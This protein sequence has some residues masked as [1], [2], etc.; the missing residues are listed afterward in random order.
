MRYKVWGRKMNATEELR[1]GLETA[2]IDGTVA[3]NM[4]F[5][6]QFVSN[7]YKEGKKVLSSIE[8]ELLACEQFQISVAFITMGGIEPLLQ[9]LKELEKKH[10]PGQILTTNYLNF[11]E[12]KALEKL[13][14]LQNITLKMYDVESAEEG[15]H[16]KGYIFKK[17]EIYRII[18]GS[19]NMTKSALTTNKEWN[20]KIISTEQGEVAGEIIKEFDDLWHSSYVLEFDTFY[21]NYKEKYNIIKRQR[22]IAKQEQVTFLEKYKLQP[23]SMQVGFISNLRKILESGEKRALLISATGTG[24]TYASAF[25]MR[26]LGFKRV[27]FLV[28]RGQL[29]RQTK[30][31][32]E[33]VFAN[34][35][36]M[37][38][39]GA[40]YHDYNK[41]YIFATVQTLNKDEHLMEYKPD[42]FD[43]I[44][45]DEAHHTSA[46]IYQKVMNYFTPK[47]WLGM[48]ATPDKRDDNIAGRNIYEIFHYQ[49]AYEIRLQQAMEE[50]LLCPFHYFGISD[51]AMLG[52]KQVNT[53]KIT[54]RD[55]NML[56]G[57][58]R[59]KHIV[60]QAHYFGYSG[61]KV[62][63]LVFCSRIEEAV[64]LSEKFNQTINPETGK[65]FRTM[66]LSGKTSEEERQRAFERLA[67]N[68]EEADKSNIP[69]DYIFSVEI[70]NEGVDIVEV[71]Q[72]IMLRP[73]ES[74][75]VFIQQLGRGLR[76]AVGKEFVVV[77]DFIGNYS[78]NFMIPIALS[79]DRSY[80]ADTIRKYVIS[81][82]NTIPGAS[83]VHFDEIAKD[84]IFA[85]IDKIKGMK[86]IIRDSYVSLKN[87]LGRVPYLLDF[88]E[89][90]EVDPLVIIKEYKTYQ[91]FLKSMEK[92]N[93]QGKFTDDEI[94]TLEY[95]SKTVLS[96]ARP[97]E[98]EILRKLLKE[99]T[100]NFEK[101]DNDFAVTYGYHVNLDSFDNAVEVLQGKFVSKEE[102]YQKYSHMDILCREE[103]R[104]LKRLIGFAKRLENAEFLR[105][106]DDIV[107]V[108]LKRYADKYEAG[109]TE[110]SPFVIYEKYSRRDVSLLMN[111]GKDLSS[112]MYGMKRIG[113][114]TFIFVTYHKEESTDDK[115]Y[116]DGKP[117]YADAFEDN[118]I[119]LWDSQMGRGT[120]SSYVEDVVQAKRKHLFVK[121]SDA[122]TGFYY[123]G[124]FDVMDVK[125]AKKKDNTGKMRDIAKLRMKM[126]HAVREDLLRYLQSNIPTMEEKAQ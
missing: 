75:I 23:N 67:M 14:A 36:S 113:D 114:D 21:E 57:E 97:Y 100:V 60:E 27:L 3:S 98:L 88:Y 11:S 52:D 92:E 91:A 89:N 37:G 79:G 76:K 48:T 12:P 17:E 90:G 15:F 64:A 70:L 45:L 85:S 117:D 38:L 105:Q 111:C 112:T 42:A 101:F 115:N 19:S 47:L 51:I 73:T 86:T 43:C 108:G 61:E 120:E 66:A 40:G 8:E 116:I 110:K 22:E 72:V 7:N 33:K 32:Y 4:A 5:K 53:K 99:G 18:I 9:T 81:G 25:A 121:K 56:T 20:T 95:L 126:H 124:Q 35:V 1:W 93:Y 13:H 24:K 78:N 102:E 65:V 96:G 55:F 2:Y 50:N 74:P 62:K 69:L 125:A 94:T 123:M 31:S 29:A 59:V 71:N 77:L 16:T 6:P 106:V 26:E 44:V 83:T 122:E 103:D 84:K 63:G 34:T 80:N 82:N 58:E 104:R 39:V 54:D 49:I 10:I 107:E 41:D 109:V 68:E 30:K 118:M 87:R 28:H 119:F 46:D